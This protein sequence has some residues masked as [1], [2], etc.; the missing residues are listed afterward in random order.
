ML[1]LKF[2]KTIE[3]RKNK[4][5]EMKKELLNSDDIDEIQKNKSKYKKETIKSIRE[6]IADRKFRS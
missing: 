5:N 2:I 4:G 6:K 1:F 3:E